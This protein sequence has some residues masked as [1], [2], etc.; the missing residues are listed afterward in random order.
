M[1]PI[2]ALLSCLFLLGAAVFEVWDYYAP[3]VREWR[4]VRRAR[5]L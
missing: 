3:R 2:A 1:E 4:R 5:R